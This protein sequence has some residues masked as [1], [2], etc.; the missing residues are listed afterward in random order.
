MGSR[1][2]SSGTNQRQLTLERLS[3]YQDVVRI[4]NEAKEVI[5]SKDFSF[6]G[7]N[8]STSYQMLCMC[9]GKYILSIEAEGEICPICGWINDFQ[10]NINPNSINGKNPVS[11]NNA[12]RTYREKL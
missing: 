8:F 6:G 1:G 7:G 3:L 2:M 11:L 10:Q 9:C 4:K 12:K 5:A